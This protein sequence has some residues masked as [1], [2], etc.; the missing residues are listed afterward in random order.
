MLYCILNIFTFSLV[1]CIYTKLVPSLNILKVYK[2]H[3]LTCFHNTIV[4]TQTLKDYL[5]TLKIRY[6]FNC[7]LKMIIV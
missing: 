7:E 4:G 6:I 2:H 5:F 1:H 3:A